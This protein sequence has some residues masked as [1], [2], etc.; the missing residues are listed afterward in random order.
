MSVGLAAGIAGCGSEA[1]PSER[2]VARNAILIVIDTLRADRVGF[3]GAGRPTSPRVDWLA[4]HGA[5]F[6]DAYA[7]SPWTVPSTASII[8]SLYPTEHGAGVM[9]T[10]RN[11]RNDAPAQISDSVPTVA[12]IL[13]SAGFRCGLFSANPYLYG[14]F[15]DGFDTAIVERMP[16]TRLMDSALEFIGSAGTSRFFAHIQFMDLHQPI[17]PPAPYFDFFP[18]PEA[19]LRDA[20]HK[21]WGFSEGEYLETREFEDFRA[22]RLALYDGALRYVDSEI[23]RLV[24]GLADLGILEETLII[25]TSDHGEEFWDHAAMEASLGGDPR[26]FYGIGHGHS[27]FQELLRVPLVFFGPG[28]KAGIVEGAP[29]SLLDIAPTLLGFLDVGKL[30]VMRGVDRHCL[31]GGSS[32]SP[33]GTADIFAESPAYGPDSWALVVD[34]WKLID[35]VDGV[36]LLFDLDNDPSESN[37]LALENPRQVR[38]LRE[39]ASRL[40]DTF[41]AIQP[42]DIQALDEATKEQLRVLGYVE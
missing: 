15:K 7:N 14:R 42:T 39:M 26:G 11:L 18:T 3:M 17:E 33:P 9:G 19:G 5:A 24:D 21:E 29:I 30:D 4:Q 27:M 41:V 22:N 2:V 23:G 1:P 28:V 6:S 25:V 16:A 34:D 38:E 35:R 10:V 13:E 37:N 32:G 8:T 12:T 31:V 36:V 40:R 20:R